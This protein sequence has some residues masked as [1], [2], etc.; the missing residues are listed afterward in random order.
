VVPHNI[1]Q[2]TNSYRYSV[3]CKSSAW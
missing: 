2:W 3:T 1:V